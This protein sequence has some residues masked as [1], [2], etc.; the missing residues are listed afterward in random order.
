[1]DVVLCGCGGFWFWFQPK[2]WVRDGGNLCSFT[3]VGTIS[4]MVVE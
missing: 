3:L 2:G 4:M 1:M